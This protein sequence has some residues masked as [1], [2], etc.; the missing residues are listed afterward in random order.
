ML[1]QAVSGIALAG[2]MEWNDETATAGQ[3]SWHTASQ[4]QQPC[5]STLQHGTCK[6]TCT[7]LYM[8]TGTGMCC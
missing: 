5:K 8:L 1:D 6:R 3:A 2:W 4:Q 7:Q